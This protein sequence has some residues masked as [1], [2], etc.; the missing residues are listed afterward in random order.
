MARPKFSVQHFIACL[1]AAWDGNPGPDTTRTLERVGYRYSIPS[2][3]EFP[4]EELEFWIYARLFRTNTVN[5]IR[6]FS[7]DVIWHDSPGGVS[8]IGG[9]TLGTVRFSDQH[10]V[11]SAAWPVR[12]LLF[13]GIGMYEFQLLVEV[14]R[15]WG[16]E[17]KSI[18]S[19][20]IRIERSS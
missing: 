8:R 20:F 16:S 6:T 13:P 11:V 3:V 15:S 2:D 14:R 17:Y 1:N 4:F 10:P 19:E 5:G 7:V 9:R 12:P 18:Q